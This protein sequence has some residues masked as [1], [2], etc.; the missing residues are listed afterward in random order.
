MIINRLLKT[1]DEKL[2]GN[3]MLDIRNLNPIINNQ[4]ERKSDN[5]IIILKQLW[6]YQEPESDQGY[7]FH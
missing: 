5:I 4:K 3:F 7:R 2:S 1:L 6:Q